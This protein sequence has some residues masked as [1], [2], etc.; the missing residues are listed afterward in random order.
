MGKVLETLLRREVL[1]LPSW[2]MWAASTVA[3]QVLLPLPQTF[4]A[5][6]G[7]ISVFLLG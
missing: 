5:S 7:V 6:G 2:E 4:P 3:D 1:F